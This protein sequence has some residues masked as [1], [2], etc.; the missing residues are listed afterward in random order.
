LIEF[1]TVMVKRLQ[2]DLRDALDS[3]VIFGLLWLGLTAIV[4]ILMPVV[5]HLRSGPGAAAEPVATQEFKPTQLLTHPASAAVIG[6]IL[7]LPFLTLLTFMLLGIEPTLGPLDPLLK[8][9]DPDQPNVLSAVIVIGALLLCVLAGLIVRGPMVQTI[10]SGG[11]LLAHPANLL[12]AVV[13]VAFI[14]R[15]VIG[16]IVDQYPCWIGVPNCD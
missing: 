10:R 6:F 3:T 4:L 9:A 15:L 8:N 7:A 5:R 16:L 12:L 2:F 11:S 1:T 13:I 14:A